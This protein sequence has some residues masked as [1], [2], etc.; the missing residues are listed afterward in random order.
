M[1][2]YVTS[3]I[4]KLRKWSYDTVKLYQNMVVTRCEDV[5]FYKYNYIYTL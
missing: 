3:L 4:K 1:H 2:V 5:R